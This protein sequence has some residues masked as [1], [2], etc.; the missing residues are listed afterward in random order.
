MRFL[1]FYD[2]VMSGFNG[3]KGILLG[4]T[5]LKRGG[6]SDFGPKKWRPSTKYCMFPMI[7][8]FS[9]SEFYY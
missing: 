3:A 9:S 8:E 5:P 6:H 2:G 7:F 1:N 4:G